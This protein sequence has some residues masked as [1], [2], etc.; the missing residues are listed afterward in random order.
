MSIRTVADV[1]FPEVVSF[2]FQQRLTLNAAF[3]GTTLPAPLITD[4]T[5]KWG[6]IAKDDVDEDDLLNFDGVWNENAPKFQRTKTV[7]IMLALDPHNAP[8]EDE[9]S[10]DAK[11]LEPGGPPEWYLD[12]FDPLEP[13]VAEA[14]SLGAQPTPVEA[15]ELSSSGR[16]LPARGRDDFPPKGPV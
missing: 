5:K 16:V 8:N 2:P 4:E 12:D 10:E 1:I 7:E 13:D 6:V 14:A 9:S 11:E 15:C 3:E